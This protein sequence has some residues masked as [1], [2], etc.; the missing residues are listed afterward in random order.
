MTSREV[1]DLRQRIKKLPGK[2]MDRVAEIIK[3]S[4]S[5]A[6]ENHEEIQVDLNQEVNYLNGQSSCK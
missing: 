1:Q 3:H 6:I 4:K 5:P 2:A